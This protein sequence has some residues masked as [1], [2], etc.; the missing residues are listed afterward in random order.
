M[1]LLQQV[2]MFFESIFKS[3]DPEVQKKIQI[4]NIENDLKNSST[5]IYKLGLLQPSFAQAMYLLQKHTRALAPYISSITDTTDNQFKEKIYIA[6]IE[7]GY[8]ESIYHNVKLLSYA[9]KKERMKTKNKN[10]AEVE[11]QRQNLEEYLKYLSTKPFLM[12]QQTLQNLD[13]FIN[14]CTFNYVNC[15]HLFDPSYNVGQT[16]SPTLKPISVDKAETI[17]QDFYFITKNLKIDVAITRAIFA[18][19]RITN[20][21]EATT[22]TQQDILTHIKTISAILNQILTSTNLTK[23]LRL[24]KKNITFTPQAMTPDENYLTKYKEKV[25]RK[26]EAEENRISTELQDE[27]LSAIIQ[28]LFGTTSLN[29]VIGYNQELNQFLQENTACSFL[30]I[31]PLEIIK[32]FL[33]TF[34]TEKVTALLNDIVVEGFFI[35]SMYKTNFSSLVYTCAEF[36]KKVHEF[37]NSFSDTGVNS[38]ALIRGYVKDSQKDIEFEKTLQ[39][40]INKINVKAK[41]LVQTIGNNLAQL[42]INIERI[43]GDS[44]KSSPEDIENIKILIQSS[45][46]YDRTEFLE[47][48]KQKWKLFIDIMKNYAII[49]NEV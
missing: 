46:N 4:R 24:S 47:K 8:N 7:T 39:V 34:F 10:M 43:L 44:K 41:D 37:E 17:L 33:N 20:P 48:S 40:L 13:L 1:A 3:S 16:E 35:D 49:N 27:T 15:I 14:V 9:E 36:S 11:Y 28:K 2:V 18:I 31:T 12:I 38:I 21:N 23:L 26:F 25:K 5:N 42:H 6:L 45:R 22:K 19:V 29:T 30:W 32:T